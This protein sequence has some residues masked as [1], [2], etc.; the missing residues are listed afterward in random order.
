MRLVKPLVM[1]KHTS[2]VCLNATINTQQSYQPSNERSSL[3]NQ[4]KPKVVVVTSSGGNGTTENK[5]HGN[6][7]ETE[8]ERHECMIAMWRSDALT[9]TYDCLSS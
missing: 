9:G 4:A 7:T 3:T 5:Q 2:T 6:V 1:D 8:D